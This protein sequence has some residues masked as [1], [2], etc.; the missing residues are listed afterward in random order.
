MKV[1]GNNDDY[2]LSGSL[3]NITDQ[4]KD[5]KSPCKSRLEVS[6]LL[7]FS[8]FVQSVWINQNGE[9]FAVGPNNHGKISSTLSKKKI[10]K[11]YQN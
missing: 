2:R 3:N 8:S 4:N 7:S 5:I 10:R 1:C 6:T 11:R 9:A